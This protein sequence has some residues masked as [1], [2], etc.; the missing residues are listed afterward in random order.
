MR[1]KPLIVLSSV[2]ANKPLNGGNARMVL[3]W[4]EGL[5]RLGAEVVPDRAAGAARRASMM[6]RSTVRGV[7]ANRRYLESVMRAHRFGDRAALVCD[8]GDTLAV[9]PFTARRPRTGRPGS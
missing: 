6:P 4:L 1:P 9:P 3:N 7:S 2:I 5:E 8:A